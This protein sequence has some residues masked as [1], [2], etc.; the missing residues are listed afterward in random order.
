MKKT[1]AKLVS[2][3]MT[4]ILAFYG[5]SASTFKAELLENLAIA[6][7]A[8]EKSMGKE[9]EAG[10]TIRSLFSSRAR[11]ARETA[12]LLTFQKTAEKIASQLLMS[13]GFLLVSGY[14]HDGDEVQIFERYA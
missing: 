8:Q 14:S 13:H 1:T 7:K 12:R 6:K 9:V 10:G 2:G 3:Y 11:I 4:L 5:E